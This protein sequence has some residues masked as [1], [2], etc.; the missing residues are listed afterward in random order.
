MRELKA[1]VQTL[2]AKGQS[3]IYDRG[4]VSL[5]C[6]GKPWRAPSWLYRSQTLQVNTRWKAL[7]EIYAMHSFAPFSNPIVTAPTT[8]HGEHKRKG[9]GGRQII[10]KSLPIFMI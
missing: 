5:A 6:F 10:F 3:Q 2:L 1:N 8:A 7:A 4:W 9:V